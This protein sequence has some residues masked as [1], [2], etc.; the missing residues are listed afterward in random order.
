M[1]KK[2]QTQAKSAQWKKVLPYLCVIGFFLI[3]CLSAVNTAKKT[4]V[5]CVVLAL[6]AGIVCFSRLRE[7]FHLPMAALAL[8][9][10]LGGIS[11]FYA[12]SGKFAL[13]EFLKVLIAF[14][15]AVALLALAKGDKIQAGRRIAVVLEW[16][17]ALSGLVSI[18]LIS[19]RWISGAVTAVLGLLSPDYAQL[20]GVEVGVR[21]TSLFGNP[22]AFAACVGIGVLLSLSLVLTAP[23]ERERAG[24]T[25]CLYI[26]ALAF[27][28]A[29]S[30]GAI[31]F[32]AVA[33]LVYLALEHKQHRAALFVLMVET[34]IVALAGTAV[35]AATSLDAWNGVQPVPLLCVV[36]GSVLLCLADKVVGRRVT[37]VLENHSRA[38]FA[39]IAAVLVAI[40]AFALLAY[41]ATGSAVLNAGESLRRSAYLEPGVYALDVQS[42]GCVNVRVASQNKHDTMMHTDTV[43]YDGAADGAAFTV[44]EDSMVVW[45]TFSAPD[46]AE[47]NSVICQG[48]RSEKV[49]LGYKLLPG[50][51]A[52]RLQGLFANQNAIQRTVFFEDGMKIF[53]RSPVIGLGLGCYEN[54]I[55]SVQSFFYETRYAHNHYIQTLAETGLIGLVLFLG[56]LVVSA[57]AIMLERR[58]REQAHPLGAALGAALVFMAGHAAVEVDFS[59]YAFLPFAFGVFALISLCCGEAMSVKWFSKKVRTWS[60]GITAV[61][62]AVFCV[63][64]INNMMAARLVKTVPTLNSLEQACRKDVFE[65]NDY[66][67]SYVLS[68]PNAADVPQVQVQAQEYAEKL[69]KVD[70]NTIPIHLAEYYLNRGQTEQGMAMV[71]KYVRYRSSDADAWARAFDL[72][73]SHMDESEAFRQG[74]VRVVT[75]LQEWNASNL[76]TI[77]LREQDMLLLNILGIAVE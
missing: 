64:L 27:V 56:L 18:D 69:S 43:L 48:A 71:E 42:S 68:A 63:F 33:F 44:P 20:A 19:T 62:V 76:G 25:V 32:I 14:C 61:L 3:V 46:G 30:M 13:H 50:F 35:V 53:A 15:M 9:V 51:I 10:L 12:V 6:A 54:G 74:A 59:F 49:P 72:L 4:A 67:L 52:N 23:S 55:M 34:L 29:F 5:F 24:H 60:L 73:L 7:R 75:A 11:T 17:A 31:A 47:V 65:R 1:A 57:A 16:G 8:V 21:M 39:A 38:L 37:A 22:N 26:N 70:S 36:A 77:R 2:Y 28:L 40:I 45:F 41:N 66:M 58:K